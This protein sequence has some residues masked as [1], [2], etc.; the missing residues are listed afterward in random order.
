MGKNELEKAFR[1]KIEELKELKGFT[2]AYKT[3]APPIGTVA[4]VMWRT[5]SELID[6][7]EWLEA[8]VSVISTITDTLGRIVP[9]A[10]LE[11]KGV[12]E[13]TRRD[14]EKLKAEWKEYKPII[15]HFNK[16]LRN[17]AENEKKRDQAAKK[18]YY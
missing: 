6:V 3:H 5:C 11:H 14:I 17:V 2:E 12:D 9:L 16:W 4:L 18:I 7:W 8:M 10:S 15:D 13:D 1:R